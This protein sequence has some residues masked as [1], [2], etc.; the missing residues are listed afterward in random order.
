MIGA[1]KYFIAITFSIPFILF[2]CHRGT[3]ETKIDTAL[4]KA[5]GLADDAFAE[6]DGITESALSYFSIGSRKENSEDS[7]ILCALKTIDQDTRTITIDFGEGCQ[8]FG[9]RVRK[10]KIIIHYSAGFFVP[11]AAIASTLQNFYINDVRVEVR[12]LLQNITTPADTLVKFHV[13]VTDGKLTWP[14]STSV[15]R[16][17][18]LIQTWNLGD[19]PMEDEI[20]VDGVANGTNRNGK[21]FII[22][23][24]T[25]LFYRRACWVFRSFI[26]VSGRKQ[27]ETEGN[28][29][30]INY[31]DGT[32]D[33]IASVLMNGQS[34]TI[35]MTQGK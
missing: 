28:T 24:S 19:T 20:T 13:V 7:L 2:A 23:I 15:T 12:R 31:G 33:R 10:G 27:I 6:V 8:G 32:C 26:P 17:S 11:G 22:N 9:G 34:L 16:E 29:M 25:P 35:D 18:D 5:D 21:N 3:M 14:D 1:I 30:T 4:L